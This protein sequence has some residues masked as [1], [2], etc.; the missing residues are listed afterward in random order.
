MVRNGVHILRI[1]RPLPMMPLNVNLLVNSVLGLVNIRSEFGT[2]YALMLTASN[3][4]TGGDA[5]V[6]NTLLLR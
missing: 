6:C 1:M 4:R 2:Q 3:V 5:M